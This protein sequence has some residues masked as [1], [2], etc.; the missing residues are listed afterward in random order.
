MEILNI[1]TASGDTLS[2]IGVAD[3]YIKM[4][5]TGD[6]RKMLQCVDDYLLKNENKSYSKY[7]ERYICNTVQY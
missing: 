4:Q 6:L 3:V 5:V 1:V 7:S 2:I